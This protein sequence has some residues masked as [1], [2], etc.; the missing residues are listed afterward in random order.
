MKK[1]LPFDL[2]T[3]I[4][5]LTFYTL[6]A[7]ACK[8][9]ES[10][11]FV[12]TL[13]VSL[14]AIGTRNTVWT[15]A[16]MLYMSIAICTNSFFMPK[17]S[18]LLTAQRGELAILGLATIMQT[19]GGKKALFIS[20]FWG[21]FIYILYMIPV[22]LAGWAPM[23][24]M[25]KIT[26]FIL[27]FFAY[28]GMTSR[29]MADERENI[30]KVRS[31]VLC[32]GIFMVVFSVFFWPFPSISQMNVADMTAEEILTK[33][34]TISLFKGMTAHSQVM[35]PLA[36]MVG[37]LTL[38]DYIFSVRKHSWIHDILLACAIFCLLKSSSRTGMGAMIAG[39]G[40]L[41]LAFLNAKG[42]G[43]RWKMA[44]LNL[45][46]GA[47]LVFIVAALAV[48]PVRQKVLGFVLKYGGSD[49]GAVQQMTTEDILA[50]R[51]GKL[52]SAIY[53]WRKSPAFG[54]GFQ[55]S[56]DMKAIKDFKSL[57][58]APVEKSTWIYAILE[59]GGTIGEIIF[60]VWLLVAVS[61]LKKRH[62]YIGL[63]TF[64]GMIVMNLGEFNIFSMTY[65]GG[66][67]WALSFAGAVLDSQRYKLSRILEI[68]NE[69]Q[70]M[71][72]FEQMLAELGQG[73]YA[74]TR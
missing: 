73:G 1:N 18:L 36:G 2:G 47:L 59:E 55:V 25:M 71:W 50:S 60:C 67:L 21:I 51:Q 20:P 48:A 26:L 34:E 16:M 13:P 38:G 30:N 6:V 28:Y 15:F 66:A 4:R 37:I 31:V 74:P 54:N 5:V 27:I 22:S 3:L 41:G 53:N 29:I 12:I 24:S 32:Y 68:R 70:Q 57:L 44:V 14:W 65:L 10:A 39:W 45:G 11:A 61:L 7:L 62:A 46:G 17:T 35:G 9:T 52:D 72:A 8:F 58:T 69:Q 40:I 49:A 56:E 19:F 42:L 23:V 63:A 43:A 64:T 33:M